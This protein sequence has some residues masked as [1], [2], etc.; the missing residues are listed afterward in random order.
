MKAEIFELPVKKLDG[1]PERSSV[2]AL[3]VQND[4]TLLC[5]L[6]FSRPLLFRVKVE[7]AK[8]AF[9][10]LEVEDGFKTAFAVTHGLR[11]NAGGDTAL[12]ILEEGIVPGPF[13][14]IMG[15]EVLKKSGEELTQFLRMQDGG[16][17]AFVRHSILQIVD[18]ELR[19][20]RSRE[21]GSLLDIAHIG[22]FVFGLTESTIW[23]EPY[24][25]SEK[26]ETLRKDLA[27]NGFI[28]RDPAGNF[29]FLGEND[30]LLRLGQTDIKAKPTPLKVP[31]AGFDV[32]APAAT[33]GFLYGTCGGSRMLFRVRINPESREEELQQIGTLPGRA[34]AM[35]AVETPP[36]PEGSDEATKAAAAAGYPPALLIA[37]EMGAGIE[38]VTL[39]L[40]PLADPE[41]IPPPPAMNSSGRIPEF[42]HASS[43]S[44]DLRDPKAP[45]VWV[46]EGR[47]GAGESGDAKPRLARFK[48]A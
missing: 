23:R 47:M 46:G 41:M 38:F 35:V 18:G 12:A 5:G 42:R 44:V 17:G 22:D 33:D 48:L 34:V 43:M 11:G 8:P 10:D 7:G 19:V 4:G 29:W 45:V 40:E 24:L 26:R 15:S 9:E 39:K 37:C 1:A 31:Q 6:S 3:E 20:R 16:F 36:A 21:P 28:H 25:N 2:T 30:R 13:R 27:S 32:S 14:S